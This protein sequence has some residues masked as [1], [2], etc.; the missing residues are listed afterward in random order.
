MEGCVS[1]KLNIK[2]SQLR[3]PRNILQ[4]GGR[5]TTVAKVVNIIWSILLSMFIT[6]R[7]G[8]RWLIKIRCNR[9]KKHSFYPLL[10]QSFHL[11]TWVKLQLDW[12]LSW[13][14]RWRHRLDL[15]IGKKKSIIDVICKWGSKVVFTSF[16]SRRPR[17]GSRSVASVARRRRRCGIK[18]CVRSENEGIWNGIVLRFDRSESWIRV[19]RIDRVKDSAPTANT[20]ERTLF[21]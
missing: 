7:Y 4:N 20:E 3:F 21:L 2:L 1:T 15:K 6:L 17:V 19:G 14:S 10:V 5:K 18:L 13:N 12:H 9:M 8:R 11:G 16:G